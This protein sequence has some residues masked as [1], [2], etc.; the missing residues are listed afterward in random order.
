[1]FSGKID[2]P[3]VQEG[4]I[5]IR[6][7]KT[8]S[9]L[10]DMFWNKLRMSAQ[11][12]GYCWAFEQLTGKRVKG[13]QIDAIRTKEPPQYVIN[14]TTS[15]SGKSQSPEAWWNES[16]CCE[17]F[18]LKDGELQQWKENV[19]ELVN[20]FFWHYQRGYFPMKTAWCSQYGKCQYYDVC[21][22]NPADR[23]IMLASGLFQDNKWTPLRSAHGK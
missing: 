5:W 21:S 14:G 12:R 7:I 13:Y 17:R 4:D 10:G 15:R 3:Y 8:T 20:E 16:L 18:Y 1:M 9:M 6:D 19:I 22:L 2:L 11:P 23:G